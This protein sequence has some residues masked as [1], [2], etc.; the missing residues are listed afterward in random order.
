MN[1]IYRYPRGCIRRGP[2]Q[3][4]KIG[5]GGMMRMCEDC[6][7]G[8]VC[9]GFE[10]TQVDCDKFKEKA[11]FVELPCKVGD[12]V[13][14]NTSIRGW[15]MRKKDRPYEARI[16]FIGLNGSDGF[17]NVELK[18]G[19][20]LQFNFS[21]IGKDVFLTYESAEKALKESKDEVKFS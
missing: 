13:Y 20:E 6:L 14:T 15:Y 1:K 17:I 3:I 21:Q 19:C 11:K 12:T 9:A 4:E 7:Y 10:V 2:L 8:D 18:E 5:I 16:L